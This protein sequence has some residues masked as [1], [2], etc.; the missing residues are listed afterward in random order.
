MKV[1]NE[2]TIK[3]LMSK[4]LTLNWADFGK[5]LLLAVLSAVLTLIVSLLKEKGFDLT[6]TDLNAILQ[7]AV[8][9]LVAY[10][11]KNL[12]TNS[13]GQFGKAE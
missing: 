2:V 11:G 1:N 9:T 10:L 6:S 7:I 5:G 3:G 8:T 13:E 4:F 12:F